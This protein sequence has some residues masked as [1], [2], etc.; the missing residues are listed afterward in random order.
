MMIA[1]PLLLGIALLALA[2]SACAQNQGKSDEVSQRRCCAPMSRVTADMV[3][4]G[5]VIDNAGSA[6]QIAIYPRARTSARPA[7]LPVA[8]VMSALRAHQVIGVDTSG[9]ARDHGD[10]RWRARFEARTSSRRSRARWNGATASATP[11]NIGL[12]FDRDARRYPP[13]RRQYRRAEP[14][15]RALRAAQQPLRRDLRDRKRGWHSSDQAALHRHRD[16]DRGSRG[17]G[18]QRRAQRNP[19]KL[20]SRGRAPAESRGRQRCADA[21][22]RRWAC[23][24]AGS[25]AP[26]RRCRAADLVKARSGAAR[27]GRHADLRSCRA[28]ISPCAA[29]RWKAAPKAT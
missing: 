25:C 4:I 28:S 3:R 6:A 15:R 10:A 22:P 24:R 18:A 1:R 29:R 8:Q 19:Q 20:P 2:T 16:R 17:A 9:F 27:P 26:A 13:R 5:D 23:R 7:P 12:T 11:A 21:R 14:G